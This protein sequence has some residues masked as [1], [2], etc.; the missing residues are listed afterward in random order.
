VLQ[1]GFT[2]VLILVIG[3]VRFFLSA[4]AIFPS[5]S[6]S[7][8]AVKSETLEDSR[9]IGQMDFLKQLNPIFIPEHRRCS[10]PQPDGCFRKE[11]RA[12]NYLG[13]TNNKNFLPRSGCS[14]ATFQIRR[15]IK[16]F[17]ALNNRQPIVGRAMKCYSHSEADAVAVCRS[18]GRAL[19][20]GCVTEV[21][22]SCSCKGRCEAV[23]AT[24]ND[25]VERGKT[26]Y[27]KTSNF[28][29]GY[30]IFVI[31]LGAVFV[32]LAIYRFYLG[33]ASEWSYFFLVAGVL[34]VGM[35][36]SCLVS[37]KRFRQK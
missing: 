37:A 35:G 21:G 22:L 29:R 24:L 27:T 1:S 15:R 11:R 23:V 25:L 33:D 4:N 3:K 34:F 16:I 31:L 12:E 17:V 7:L 14:H 8:K 36:F 5:V 6:S 13:K 10:Q 2:T 9:R 28:Q 18:C 19:C 26:A 30:G 20:R 32:S